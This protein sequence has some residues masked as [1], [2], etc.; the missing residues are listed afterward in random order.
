MEIGR[1]GN[2]VGGKVR[3]I[4]WVG[5]LCCASPWFLIAFIHQCTGNEE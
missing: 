2:V 1:V 5:K 4:G 3:R